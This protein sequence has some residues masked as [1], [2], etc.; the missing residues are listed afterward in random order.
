MT[1]SDMNNTM[2]TRA[3]IRW[4]LLLLAALFS[5]GLHAETQDNIDVKPEPAATAASKKAT[6]PWTGFYGGFSAGAIIN[7]TRLTADQPGLI[8]NPSTL[9]VS[10]VSFIPGFD[11]GYLYHHL[12]SDIVIGAELYFSFPDSKSNNAVTCPCSSFDR[13]TVKNRVQGAI[14]GR[15]GY[16]HYHNG[17]LPYIIGGASFADTAT[18]YTNESN[19]TYRNSDVATGWIAGAGLEYRLPKTLPCVANICIPITAKA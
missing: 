14:L 15:L 7:Q 13:F 10:S 16:D 3:E 11:A 4:G 8:N 1:F 19:Q 6:E 2:K 17:I 5:N 9:N 12:D 18:E